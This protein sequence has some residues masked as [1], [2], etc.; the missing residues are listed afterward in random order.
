[1]PPLSI[2]V[3]SALTSAPTGA[4]DVVSVGTMRLCRPTA[5]NATISSDKYTGE[6][7]AVIQLSDNGKATF[8]RVTTQAV[9]KRLP[10]TLN[11]DTVAEPLVFEPILGGEFTISGPDKSV[12]EQVVKAVTS[13]C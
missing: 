1:M 6:P 12:L 13:D 5:A 10:I 4:A 8:A 2:L 3:L 9:G 11:G 7:V